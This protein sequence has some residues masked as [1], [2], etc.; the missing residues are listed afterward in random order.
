MAR[1]VCCPHSAI[2]LSQRKF[3]KPPPSAL[4]GNPEEFGQLPP[5]RPSAYPE[6]CRKVPMEVTT[7]RVQ[8]TDARRC[9]V[10]WTGA[11]ITRLYAFLVLGS[12]AI[13]HLPYH[14]CGPV[15]RRCKG[16]GFSLLSLTHHDLQLPRH[17][18]MRNANSCY[19]APDAAADG[20][21]QTW[22]EWCR[23]ERDANSS[24]GS[25]AGSTLVDGSTPPTPEE[26]FSDSSSGLSAF[27]LDDIPEIPFVTLPPADF[28][29]GDDSTC[30][31]TRDERS[32]WPSQLRR[33]KRTRSPTRGPATLLN[34]IDR[35]LPQSRQRS[36]SVSSTTSSP[37]RPGPARSI[38]SSSSSIR[39]RTG[40]SPSSVKF[41]EM[42]TIHYEEED[43]PEPHY[44][45]AVSAVKRKASIL[46]RLLGPF[47]KPPPSPEK[48]AISGPFPL[49]ET[50]PKQVYGGEACLRSVKSSTSLRSTRSCSSRLQ[51]YWGRVKGRDP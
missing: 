25:S 9:H 22:L 44:R 8:F 10:L 35:P 7:P 29:C 2:F 12:D 26:S 21:A 51:S 24:W 11:F 18:P 19:L 23:A 32:Y 41:L 47:R 49:W 17:P 33:T 45:Q 3:W 40:R 16:V 34:P 39:T 38:L 20:G 50:P 5:E 13:R 37:M 48:P 42:P 31:P 4:S 28:T 14:T 43:E 30:Q 46:Q 6:Q 15:H 1:G 27:D 36:T